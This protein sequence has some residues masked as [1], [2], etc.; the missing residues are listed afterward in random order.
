MPAKRE[1]KMESTEARGARTRR[2]TEFYNW[3][4]L[5]RQAR[6]EDSIN[7]RIQKIIMD[8]R[9]PPKAKG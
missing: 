6:I 3:E 1:T 8:F 9:N 7:A 4:Q 5:A 2:M